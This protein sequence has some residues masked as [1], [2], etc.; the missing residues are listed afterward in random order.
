[1]PPATFPWRCLRTAGR[2]VLL[3]TRRHAGAM[4]CSIDALG[5]HRIDETGELVR[6]GGDHLGAIQSAAH[7]SVVGAQRGLTAAQGGGQ[8]QCLR[9]TIGGALA[10]A[11]V[12]R[13]TQFSPGAG[14]EISPP[15]SRI[16]LFGA[17]ETGFQL[18][19]QTLRIAPD[20]QGHGVVQ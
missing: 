7:S 18:F 19:F 8:A 15:G 20:V 4:L 1:M 13:G 3:A 5:Q 10:G 9:C 14:I 17:D 16:G 11:G 12:S 2:T 6:R